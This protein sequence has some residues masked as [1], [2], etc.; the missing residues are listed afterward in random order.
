MKY[1]KYAWMIVKEATERM[2][3]EWDLA[4]KE[5]NAF[6][7]EYFKLEDRFNVLVNYYKKALFY[8]PLKWTLVRMYYITRYQFDIAI[9]QSVD[10]TIIKATDQFKLPSN[11][12]IEKDD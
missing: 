8:A 1:D 10:D 3:F 5:I 11:S 7:E 9:N 6:N 4:I 12:K 2:V